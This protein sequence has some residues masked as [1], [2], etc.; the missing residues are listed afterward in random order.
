[1]NRYPIPEP[2]LFL[3]TGFYLF[4]FSIALALPLCVWRCTKK[5]SQTTLV[6]VL[7]A[8]WLTT[9]GLLTTWEGFRSFQPP[10]PFA[11]TVT[12]GLVGIAILVFSPLG[13]ELVKNLTLGGLVLFQAFRFPLELLMHRA[14]TEGLMPPQMSYS[15]RNFDILTGISAL[16]LG[17]VLYRRELSQSIVWA[18]NVIGFG[19]LV[20]I[21]SVALLSAPSPFR[22]FH[23]DPPNVWVLDVPFVWLPMVMVLAAFFG[24]LMVARKLWFSRQMAP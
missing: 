7:T 16:I 4:A 19:L 6:F 21:V 10:P 9:T 17:I 14:Y 13:T 5:A 23:N 12:T 22:Q 2:S 24:H 3:Q 18:W 20:N 15:G 11:V 8:A 1:M